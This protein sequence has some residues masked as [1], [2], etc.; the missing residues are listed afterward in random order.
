MG[1][2]FL[3]KNYSKEDRFDRVIVDHC[4]P[5]LVCAHGDRDPS[6]FSLAVGRGVPHKLPTI[7]KLKK[8][9]Q[10]KVKRL[11]KVLTGLAITVA[12]LVI[13]GIVYERVGRRHDRQRFTQIGKSFDVGGRTLNICCSGSGS[14][15]VI[16]EGK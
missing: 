5:G 11:F 1:R 8:G 12:F 13:A 2:P 10:M 7:V 14:P 16:L 9:D 3:K 15:T 6:C 4:G